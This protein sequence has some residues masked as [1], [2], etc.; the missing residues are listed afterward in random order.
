M[1]KKYKRFYV[2]KLNEVELI[3]VCKSNDCYEYNLFDDMSKNNL[4]EQYFG[5]AKCYLIL[6][7]SANEDSKETENNEQNDDLT[8]L[9][10]E[11][12]ILTESKIFIKNGNF[13]IFGNFNFYFRIRKSY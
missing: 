6:D 9:L 8:R 7:K 10:L 1:K 5:V 13:F 2:P 11:K 4:L 3:L 12:E